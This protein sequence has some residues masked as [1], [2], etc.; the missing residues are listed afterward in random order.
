MKICGGCATSYPTAQCRGVNILSSFENNLTSKY[1]YI[2][3]YPDGVM[4]T[5]Y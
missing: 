1:R 2:Y 3:E 5:A 4:S